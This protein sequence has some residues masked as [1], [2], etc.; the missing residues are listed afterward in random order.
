MNYYIQAGVSGAVHPSLYAQIQTPR[1]FVGDQFVP[2]DQ[3]TSAHAAMIQADR[4]VDSNRP[5]RLQTTFLSP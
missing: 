5:G 4:L 2:R 1:L 3:I